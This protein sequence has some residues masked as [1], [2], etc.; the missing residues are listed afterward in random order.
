[1][2]AVR[3]SRSL[4]NGYRQETEQLHAE[5]AP[6][7][8]GMFIGLVGGT[9]PLEY[10][11]SPRA[12]ARLAAVL[13]RRDPRLPA[14]PPA[15]QAAAAASLAV[16]GERR[17][18]GGAVPA[19]ERVL[20]GG[21]GTGRAG[22]HGQPVPDDRHLSPDALGA[23]RAGDSGGDLG[24]RLRRD[25]E[26]HDDGQPDTHLSAVRGRH[27]RNHLDPRGAASRAAPLRDPL[28]G[29]HARGR[30]VGQPEPG[31]DRQGDQRRAGCRRRTRPD[32]GRHPRRP[33][34]RLEP[35]PAARGGA[36]RLSAGRQRRP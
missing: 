31:G 2:P 33:R 20:P 28:R 32:R 16:A 24:P 21:G 36:L 18:V 19:H 4:V 10:Y 14:A 3:S 9:G 5:R 22:G 26:R 25:V 23:A 17:R 27:R 34:L 29:D 30:G 1:M 7:A 15:A 12:P 8:F 6:L 35:D 13:R 11:F